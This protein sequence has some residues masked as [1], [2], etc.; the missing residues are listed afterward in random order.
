MV[1]WDD[2]FW[3]EKPSDVETGE[4]QK[5]HTRHNKA[6]SFCEGSAMGSS[7]SIDLYLPGEES[8][9]EGNQAPPQPSSY[10]SRHPTIPSRRIL[11]LN[12]ALRN[13]ILL[14]CWLVTLA[15][16]IP[17][18]HFSQNSVPLSASLLCS[19]WLTTL[20][21]QT[22]IKSCPNLPRWLRTLLSGL[23]NPVLWTSLAMTAYLFLDG[24]AS[25]R[26]L[27]AMLDTLETHTPLSKLILRA[28]S[29]SSAAATTATPPAPASPSSSSSA[30]HQPTSASTTTTTTMG[31]A[32][33]DIAV[34]ILNS[35]LVAWGLKLYEYRGH[36]L[37]R[38]GVTVL[39]VSAALALANVAC[40]PLLA[41]AVIG[42]GVGVGSPP[43][44]PA[45]HAALALAFAARS[46]TI[47]LGGPAM[48]ALG[49]DAGLNAAMVVVSGIVFQMALGFGV[50]SWLEGCCCRRWWWWEGRRRRRSPRRT[51]DDD[52]VEM[53]GAATSAAA[54]RED[55]A[56][57][58]AVGRRRRRRV[59]DPRT[60]AAGVM[61][62]VNAAAMGTAYLY[63][64]QSDAAPHSALSMMALGIMT[65][66]F[67][68][69]TP[70]ARWV[71]ESVA[72]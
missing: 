54:Q 48:A 52:D 68:A 31:M 14:L 5:P 34:T 20:A 22:G 7:P 25:N 8:S 72:A 3:A 44:D 55:G 47:A 71:A 41:R 23:S 18:R 24:A 26:P 49:G 53:D 63:E 38:A 70:L 10:S 43:P 12:W 32:A 42:V 11:L 50:G 40:G 19:L 67:S 46:V 29:D 9:T 64:A 56:D 16:G 51:G 62:G 57:A 33:G 2:K 58:G 69:I 17:H 60:V 59:N 37:S 13:P 35:G 66:V 1:L 4:G 6:K 27:Q 21:L 30:S 45:S 36:L 61:V 28:L 15:V 65:V 39:S